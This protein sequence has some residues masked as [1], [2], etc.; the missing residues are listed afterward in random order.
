M[1]L[2]IQFDNKVLINI[3]FGHILIIKTITESVVE[4]NVATNLNSSLVYLFSNFTHFIEYLEK[5]GDLIIFYF[6]SVLNFDW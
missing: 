4:K 6:I 2:I 1:K 3:I 5:I